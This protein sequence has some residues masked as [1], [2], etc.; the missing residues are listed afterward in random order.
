M[1]VAFG[2]ENFRKRYEEALQSTS[3][4][5]S[6]FMAEV[7]EAAAVAADRKNENFRNTEEGIFTAF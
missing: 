3:C 6:G 4:L 1:K 5:K 2:C 7:S